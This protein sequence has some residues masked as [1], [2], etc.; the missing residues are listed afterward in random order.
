MFYPVKEVVLVS[1]CS[2]FVV[3]ED[4]N[5]VMNCQ[6]TNM[7]CFLCL[8]LDYYVDATHY[9]LIVWFQITIGD[10]SRI[11]RRVNC[12]SVTG[13]LVPCPFTAG[14]KPSSPLVLVP[15]LCTFPL[16]FPECFSQQCNCPP[17]NILRGFGWQTHQHRGCTV[18]GS[19]RALL[20]AT[21]IQIVKR[22]THLYPLLYVRREK[23]VFTACFWVY[24]HYLQFKLEKAAQT[25]VVTCL[26]N[27]SSTM[28]VAPDLAVK[29]SGWCLRERNARSGM[30]MWRACKMQS[31]RVLK[32]VT[33]C[34][35]GDAGEPGLRCVLLL[36]A[37]RQQEVPGGFCCLQLGGQNTSCC[38]RRA[39]Q[40]LP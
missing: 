1:V 19:P 7:C 24:T 31:C 27:L 23:V 14:Q 5:S 6:H 22:R 17:G 38:Q 26:Q 33:H 11:G 21:I 3:T 36:R 37:G 40:T 12:A 34:R 25:D 28:L 30:V 13:L 2:S 39:Y 9:A 8:M 18:P 35:S 20:S 32:K 15:G 29:F 16:C 10:C 4:A